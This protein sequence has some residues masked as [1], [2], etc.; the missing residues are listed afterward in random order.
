MAVEF[1]VTSIPMSVVKILIAC[2]VDTSNDAIKV[3]S[4]SHGGA[5]PLILF[6]KFSQNQMNLIYYPLFFMD[7]SSIT[8]TFNQLHVIVELELAFQEFLASQPQK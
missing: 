3:I 6:C 2:G 1:I 4:H 8:T 5:L 7:L